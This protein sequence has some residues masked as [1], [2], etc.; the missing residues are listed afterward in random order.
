[1]HG[2]MYLGAILGYVDNC[3]VKFRKWQM[4]LKC[5]AGTSVGALVGVLITLWSPWRIL[6]F[7]KT[8]GFRNLDEK[9]FDQ[10]WRGVCTERCVNSGRQLNNILRA[11]MQESTGSCHTTFSELYKLTGIKF[12]V[13]ATNSS[14]GRTQYWSHANVPDL[15]VWQ[16][17]RASV[18]VPFVFPEFEVNGQ[19][20]MDGGV[21]CN[22]PCHL[23]P[24]H[25]TLV[26]YVQIRRCSA[27]TPKSLLDF[28]TNAAQLGSFRLQPLYALNSIPCV[29]SESSVSPFNFGATPAE[30]DSLLIRGIHCWNA[31]VSRNQILVLSCHTLLLFLRLGRMPVLHA[32]VKGGCQA[33]DRRRQILALAHG[34]CDSPP[35]SLRESPGP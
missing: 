19:S 5:V 23:F 28:Y 35:D 3:P 32:V 31:V 16:A 2:V 11:G 24:A 10:D 21:T 9:L 17:L 30:L 26:L 25:R 13:T 12:I 27:L 33:F 34:R 18:S 14:T 22:L 29:P 15:Q 20:Y 1:M 7:V 6:E 8:A 4:E